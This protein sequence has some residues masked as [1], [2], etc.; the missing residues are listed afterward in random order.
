MIKPT[1]Y[2][3]KLLKE[4]IGIPIYFLT[5]LV[6]KN[7]HLWV[8]GEWLGY[9]YADNSKYLFEYVNLN[10]PEIVAIWLSKDNTIV[11]EV[12]SKGF[13][14]YKSYS[15]KGSLLSMRAKVHVVTHDGSDTNTYFCGGSKLMMLTHGT[16]LKHQGV[17]LQANRM[18]FFTTFVD[19]YGPYIFP[20]K[21]KYDL[22]FCADELAQTRFQSAFPTAKEVLPF[23]YPRWD[24]YYSKEQNKKLNE[25]V[26][27]YDLVISF[28]PTLRFYNEIQYDPFSVE[29]FNEFSNFLVENNYLLLV[30]PHPVMRLKNENIENENIKFVGSNEF[31][32]VFDIFNKT[33]ILIT[34]YSSVMFDF[35]ITGRKIILLT[36]DLDF[37][38]NEDVGVYGDFSEDAIG[39]VV[40]NWDEVISI[41]RR[42]EDII[43]IKYDFI[44]GDSS[45]KI[46]KYIKKSIRFN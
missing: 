14:A 38:L 12:R 5:F 4:L 13:K 36:P 6:P 33:D 42:K 22:V 23:G 34:D 37:Y 44:E 32:N 45:K 40:K 20:L 18:G 8:F 35:K 41:L 27:R 17:D 21:R 1:Y 16:P 10:H 24:A 28:M 25:I 39:E 19:R 31:P 30:R 29:G 3:K 15:L 46:I 43:P 2:L 7:K 9:R 11:D 26:E